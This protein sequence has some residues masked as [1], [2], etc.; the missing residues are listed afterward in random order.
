MSSESVKY[1]SPLSLI[2]GC[3]ILLGIFFQDYFVLCVVSLL[4]DLFQ[5]ENKHFSSPESKLLVF[6]GTNFPTLR[7]SFADK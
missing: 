2:L 7:Y 3:N 6:S 1:N 4:G 5:R